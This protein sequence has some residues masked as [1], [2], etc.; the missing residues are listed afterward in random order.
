M[1]DRTAP[2]R[3]CNQCGRI[4]KPSSGNHRGMCSTLCRFM[5]K[6]TFAQDGCWLWT[7]SLKGDGYGSFNDQSTN[8]HSAH[9]WAF[10]HIGVY[11]PL[12]DGLTLDHL[13]R[14]RACVNPDHLQQ[15]THAEN[16]RRSIGM[17]LRTHCEKAC[18]EFTPE[19]TG[20]QAGGTK[21]FC[22][23]CKREREAPAYYARKAQ[24]NV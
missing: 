23:Q 5:E 18:H 21:R 13:C 22:R 3:P 15:V 1:R 19:N 7:G 9:R 20:W 17:N 6:V 10:A 2:P 11:R 4:F 8:I 16:V 14:V 24:A 12:V